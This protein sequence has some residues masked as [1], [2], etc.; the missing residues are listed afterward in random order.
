M[1]D[2]FALIVVIVNAYPKQISPHIDGVGE[3]AREIHR[4]V[5]G[6][7]HTHARVVLY[8]HIRIMILDAY[9]GSAGYCRLDGR[10]CCAANLAELNHISKGKAHALI[11]EFL[12][13]FYIVLRLK[14]E[15]PL[16]YYYVAYLLC[17]RIVALRGV[18]GVCN[19]ILS[20]VNNAVVCD[21]VAVF[22]GYFA[23]RIVYE[24]VGKLDRKRAAEV[25][26]GSGAEDYFVVFIISAVLEVE[27][28]D[29]ACLV[30]L[31]LFQA[32]DCDIACGV[33]D[34]HID[35]ICLGHEVAAVVHAP[36]DYIFAVY[37]I[38]ELPESGDVVGYNLLGEY[39]GVVKFNRVEPYFHPEAVGHRGVVVLG[40][41]S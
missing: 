40:G 13:Q 7:L 25:V 8:L 16:V 32:L 33:L 35:Y 22:V 38:V 31:N 3:L 37:V 41:A 19:L 1:D 30:K 15:L 24:R 4:A 11:L 17:A 28:G 23:V 20:G 29:Y 21:G 5:L 36:L 34:C 12:G 26:F 6:I 39:L 18:Y 27:D 9:R 14:L 10:E 2:N